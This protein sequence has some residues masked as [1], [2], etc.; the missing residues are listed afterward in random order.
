MSTPRQAFAQ[1]PRLTPLAACVATLFALASTSAFAA[2]YAPE[3]G[4][5]PAA[6]AAVVASARAKANEKPS[7]QPMIAAVT[8]CNDDGSGSLRNAMNGAV[9]GDT[10][11]LSHLPCSTITLTTGALLAVVDNLTLL[12]PADHHLAID[13]GLSTHHYNNAIIH[14]GV[15]T[16]TM[17]DLTIT[18]AKYQDGAGLG[19]CIWSQGSVYLGR[20][21]VSDCHVAN[22]TAS[23][24][25]SGAGVW[26]SG[27]VIASH[28][29][30][31]DNKAI[32]ENATALGGGIYAKGAVAALATTVS[33]N[34]AEGNATSEGGGIFVEG[35]LL[36]SQTT[37]SD[38][39]SSIGGGLFVDGR[40]STTTAKVQ[41]STISGNSADA[42][43][44]V[45]ARVSTNFDNDTIAY[46]TTPAFTSA[47]AAA[48][49]YLEFNSM[50]ESTIVILNIAGS[51]AFDVGGMNGVTI[52]G[53]HNM[54]H[55]VSG[56]INVAPSSWTDGNTADIF[57]LADYGGQTL[58]HALR[59]GTT[60][61]NHGSNVPNVT[62]DQRGPSF[63]RV[64]GSSP[65]IGAF[66]FNPDIIFVNGFN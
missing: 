60:A 25:A 42:V 66:E 52:T 56:F 13:G 47:S 9:T 1:T 18:D 21:V 29:R 34:Q 37:L 54:F 3:L 36:I 35:D 40:N 51:A 2:P 64:V 39:H 31:V 23:G 41:N 65:D 45:F 49:L 46:N 27:T 53:A 24:N 17:K 48:G 57:P 58:T 43:G 63:P 12:G 6:K 10:V 4:P 50:V 55:A 11:D 59:L 62:Q 5:L 26:A 20:S 61:I 32:S 28:S 8:N 19:G 15:G 30:V 16:L 44:G 7:R 22:T 38:N 14:G 33:G